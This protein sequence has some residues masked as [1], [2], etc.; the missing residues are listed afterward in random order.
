MPWGRRRRG[1][2]ENG[3][4]EKRT[5]RQ[6]TRPRNFLP[7]AAETLHPDPFFPGQDVRC[8]RGGDTA[9]AEGPSGAPGRAPG[10]G[11]AQL[12]AAA[13][14]SVRGWDLCPARQRRATGV[15][16]WGIATH[17]RALPP[18]PR[19]LRPTSGARPSIPGALP[20]TSGGLPPTP[21]HGHSGKGFASPKEEFGKWKRGRN[22]VRGSSGWELSHESCHTEMPP[23]LCGA[24][25][26]YRVLAS[27]WEQFAQ[28]EVGKNREKRHKSTSNLPCSWGGSW[29]QQEL[30]HFA[31]QDCII[32]HTTTQTALPISLSSLFSE[33]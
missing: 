5:P 8:G 9:A 3:E 18:I 12:M 32:C 28:R 4:G 20:P 33:K 21:G 24:A 1:A 6:E 30:S 29:M 26:I 23:S 17:P 19:A 16:P 2:Q 15:Y 31:V 22:G 11:R 13:A 14:T 10:L 25:R 7:M 27:D